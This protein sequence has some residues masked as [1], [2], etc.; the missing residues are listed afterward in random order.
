MSAPAE[1]AKSAEPSTLQKL[2]IRYNA[3][4]HVAKY[5][6]AVATGFLVT[7]LI[8]TAG[9]F[10]VYHTLSVPSIDSFTPTLL[11]LNALAFGIGVTVAFFL[12]EK[13]SAEHQEVRGGSGA[14]NTTVRLLKFQLVSLAGNL[15]TIGV[16]LV[17]LRA[18][19]I[20]PTLGNIVG[21]IVAF[22]ISYFVSM[23]IVWRLS[24]PPSAV[25][26]TM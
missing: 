11:E 2:K 19:G 18:F 12:N 26:K 5:G 25:A 9:V 6:I 21:A 24:R 20:P 23:K 4:F 10:A 8:L 13:I 16:Q 3:I 14:W 17:L 1:P 15:V 22:P 7:E